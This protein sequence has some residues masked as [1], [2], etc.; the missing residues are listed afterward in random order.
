MHTR[1]V[2]VG[3]SLVDFIGL[4][5]MFSWNFAT[6]YVGRMG[7]CLIRCLPV[8]EFV[9]LQ[10]F[11]KFSIL[12]SFGTGEFTYSSA[13]GVSL[14][15]NKLVSTYSAK[16][17]TVSGMERIFTRMVLLACKHIRRNFRVN[18]MVMTMVCA[19]ANIKSTYTLRTLR[20]HTAL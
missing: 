6:S 14:S 4:L 13:H 10:L 15:L 1:P 16:N 11:I 7:C 20:Y 12:H 19:C 18:Q 17:F 9:S 2:R 5:F 3:E 8:T